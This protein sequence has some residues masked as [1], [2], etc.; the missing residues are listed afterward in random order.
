MNQPLGDL[1]QT[2]LRFVSTGEDRTAGDDSSAAPGLGAKL[3]NG[4]VVPNVQIHRS[5]TKA[6]DRG[7]KISPKEPKRGPEHAGQQARRR[8]DARQGEDQEH[9]SERASH[10]VEGDHA[11]EI[12]AEHGNDSF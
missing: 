11:F 10:E 9:S 7:R 4:S 1:S 6:D 12:P 2:S 3:E 5:D 8:A